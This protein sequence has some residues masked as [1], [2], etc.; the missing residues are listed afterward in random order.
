MFLMLLPK[1][2]AFRE[3]QPELP[4]WKEVSADLCGLINNWAEKRGGVLK[5]NSDLSDPIGYYC[6]SENE[7]RIFIK[8]LD[9]D[10]LE[11]HIHSD[12]LA[13][14]LATIG[15]TVSPILDGYPKLVNNSKYAV[16]AYA[17]EDGRFSSPTTGDLASI[18]RALGKLH[19]ALRRCPWSVEITKSGLSQYEV[20]KEKLS[21]IK[22]GQS[23]GNIP[24]SVIEILRTQGSNILDILIE[25]PQVIHGDLNFGNI[26]FRTSDNEVL[27]LDFEDCSSAWFSPLMDVS[28]VIERFTLFNSDDK[29]A[30]LAN[31][32]LRS[33]TNISGIAFSHPQQLSRILQALSIRSLILLS[34]VA[35]L[36]PETADRL[37]WEKFQKLHLQALQRSALLEKISRPS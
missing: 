27:F 8:V 3:L 31:A 33:Y 32:F 5:M 36:R 22:S 16:L 20:L 28:F 21:E 25:S 12:Q 7:T 10:C 1:A 29:S 13:K 19:N 23:K 4:E 35:S 30:E 11:S 14:W 15:V 9:A 34:I 17:Y 2:P 37:E 26:V 18:G 24:E 6:L